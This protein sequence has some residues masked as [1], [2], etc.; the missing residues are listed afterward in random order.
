MIDLQDVRLPN[1]ARWAKVRP[2]YSSCRSLE[3]KY[4]SPQTWHEVEPKTEIDLLDAVVIEKALVHP[5]FPKRAREIIKYCYLMPHLHPMKV[6]RK[7]GIRNGEI[8]MELRNAINMLANRLKANA[9]K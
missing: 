5:A 6:C 4:K 8:D 1:W 9:H 2:H 7:L 3:H